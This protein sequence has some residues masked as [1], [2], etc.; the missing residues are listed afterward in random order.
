VINAAIKIRKDL[1]LPTQ[2][3]AMGTVIGK[4]QGAR[5]PI[6]CVVLSSASDQ[7]AD[8]EWFGEGPVVYLPNCAYCI[9]TLRTAAS[10][11][12]TGKGY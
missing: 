10:L 8:P 12:R 4:V 7:D 11:T 3:L 6:L 9:P 2:A 1:T 5:A